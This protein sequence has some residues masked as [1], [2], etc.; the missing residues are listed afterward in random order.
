MKH[1]VLHTNV[2]II[3][4]KNDQKKDKKRVYISHVFLLKKY[5]K[6]TLLLL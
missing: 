5:W 3:K 4:D 6:R 1:I 2:V